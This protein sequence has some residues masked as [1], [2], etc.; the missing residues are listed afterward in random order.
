MINPSYKEFTAHLF[1]VIT[2]D[3]DTLI[4][5]VTK[6]DR[7]HYYIEFQQPFYLPQTTE[8]A[9]KLCQDMDLALEGKGEF[10]HVY[11]DSS[12]YNY[13]YFDSSNYNFLSDDQAL[14]NL[15]FEKISSPDKRDKVYSTLFK[16]IPH[17]ELLSSICEIFS[18]NDPIVVEVIPFI[19]NKIIEDKTQAVESEVEKEHIFSRN[20]DIISNTITALKNI[21]IPIYERVRKDI[22]N[23]LEEF[24]PYLEGSGTREKISR[25]IKEKEPA[26]NWHI[27]HKFFPNGKFVVESNESL[28]NE[29]NY[30]AHPFN[31]N[32]KHLIQN[33]PT[34]T[35]ENDII[36]MLGTV[37]ELINTKKE[38]VGIKS[39]Q[40]SPD[41]KYGGEIEIKLFNS[42]IEENHI[43]TEKINSIQEL[44]QRLMDYYQNLI[45]V[46]NKPKEVPALMEKGFNSLYFSMTLNSS[47]PIKT[48]SAKKI[49]I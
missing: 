5:K 31:I 19:L 10:P 16:S 47:L 41:Y 15:L 28:F 38:T 18:S 36:S 35:N 43:K 32:Y 14:V 37:T 49:K 45:I 2:N 29:V 17:A 22:Y 39:I 33:Y 9:K 8:L 21:D 20:V 26:N 1:H 4:K 46:G 34:L 25:F 24:E 48:N 12:N 13:V 40:F 6:G 11:F 23:I 3:E 27:F 42:D 30:T 7:N 44:S